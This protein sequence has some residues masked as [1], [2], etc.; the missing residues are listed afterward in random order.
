MRRRSITTLLA[1]LLISSTVFLSTAAVAVPPDEQLQDPALEAKAREISKG[2]RCLVCQNQSIDDSDAELA[3]DLRRIVRERLLAG[4]N[5]ATIEDYVVSRY[6]EFVLL[7][8]RLNASTALLWGS[9]L[10]FV[11]A[12]L[13]FAVL[14]FRRKDAGADLQETITT[15]VKSM[16]ILDHLRDD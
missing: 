6:G 5:E 10:L 3:K 14:T 15:P 1:G 9:P 11:L 8:P 12:G 7:N 16:N 13:G 2:L 4:D